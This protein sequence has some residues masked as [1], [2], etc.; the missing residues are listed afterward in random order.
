VHC[1]FG[2]ELE[3]G[4]PGGARVRF[5]LLRSQELPAGASV[6]VYH[7]HGTGNI[8]Y[9]EP[10]NATPV[11]VWSCPQ[12]KAGL[13]MA[14]FGTGD[15][16]YEA[17]AAVGLGKGSFGRGPFG[18]DADVMEWTSPVLPPGQYRFGVKVI[19]GQGNESAGSET[20]SIAVVPAAVPAARL[21]IVTFDEATERLTLG[22]SEHQ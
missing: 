16:G 6:N 5:T 14:P 22:I 7:D 15:F 12:D 2:A 20:E 21:D 1:D 10:L 19:D 13:G 3:A 4:P 17:G 9:S 11:R 8:D 18:L